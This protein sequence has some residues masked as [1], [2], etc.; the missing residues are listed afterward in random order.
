MSL[1]TAKMASM[2]DLSCVKA[3]STLEEIE[4]AAQAAKD[5]G[6]ICVFAMP[7]HTPYLVEQLKDHPEILIGGVV[8]FPDGSA[9][10]MGKVAEAKEMI[11]AGAN[12]LDMV[13][14]ITWMK[15]GMHDKVRDDIKAVVDAAGKTPVKVIFECHYLTDKE[16]TKACELAIEAGASWVKTGTGWA[17]TGATL[18]NIELMS[19]TVAGR[20][21]VKAAGGVRDRET[22][23]KMYELGAERFGV[24]VRTA[25][26]ILADSETSG[27]SY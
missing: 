10:T 20:C 3:D 2:M 17:E 16:I 24:G 12:E 19:K 23:E 1:S 25:L 7:A 9:S 6:C 14:N 18:H 26:A 11:E 27:D 8:G 4:N 22:L 21:K 5:Y 13:M 15:A